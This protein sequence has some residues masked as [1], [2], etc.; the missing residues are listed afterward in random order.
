MKL[1][2]SYFICIWT[3]LFF[4]DTVLHIIWNMAGIDYF[5]DWFIAYEFK[6]ILEVIQG[7]HIMDN[8]W[9]GMFVILFLIPWILWILGLL[10]FILFFVSLIYIITNEKKI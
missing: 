7:L 1:F 9:L 6:I 2:I 4:V 5:W 8:M 3:G 10:K